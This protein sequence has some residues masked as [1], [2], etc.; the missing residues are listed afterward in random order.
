MLFLLLLRFASV[1]ECDCAKDQPTS[2][3]GETVQLCV[4]GDNNTFEHLELERKDGKWTC[5]AREDVESEEQLEKFV[6]KLAP[7]K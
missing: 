3:A 5:A 6:D 1:D 2:S 7:S 4:R